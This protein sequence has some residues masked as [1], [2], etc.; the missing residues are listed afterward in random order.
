MLMAPNRAGT[1]V[2]KARKAKNSSG[3]LATPFSFP[4][5]RDHPS[6]VCRKLTGAELQR[7]G[8]L[9]RFPKGCQ[10]MF[11]QEIHSSANSSTKEQAG[12]RPPSV[13]EVSFH[14]M[15]IQRQAAFFAEP[16]IVGFFLPVKKPSN[17]R[18]QLDVSSRFPPALITWRI[19]VF[20][21]IRFQIGMTSRA[22]LK[23]PAG[24][25]LSPSPDFALIDQFLADFAFQFSHG[26]PLL[27]SQSQSASCPIPPGN[28]PMGTLHPA[29]ARYD[30]I[31]SRVNT[32]CPT[33]FR[34]IRLRLAQAN[35]AGIEGLAA[36]TVGG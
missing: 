25:P 31:G 15:I 21:G 20:R 6:G 30:G 1:L 17:A 34:G 32:F 14:D 7:Y 8:G 26:V 24:M 22:D 2:T 36:S 10:L 19:R 27:F 28:P 4:S 18:N 35:L 11:R 33:S 12:G 5:S 3:A 23:Y 29:R 13:C 9:A 16:P